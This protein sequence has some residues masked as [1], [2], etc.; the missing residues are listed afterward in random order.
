[1][2]S[3][4]MITGFLLEIIVFTAMATLDLEFV[5]DYFVPML[6]YTVILS[7]LSIIII[8]VLSR[9]CL[10]HEWFE[11]A[12]MAIGAATG[13]TSTGLALV[14]ALDPDSKSS[15]G[16]THGIYSTIMSWK[17]LFT[18]LTPLWLMTGI[19]LTVG[20]GFAIMII[21]CICAFIFAETRKA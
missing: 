7:V 21:S 15:A 6:I 2:K 11:K 12:C 17:D 18:G 9:K 10:K 8:I 14:R 3:I 20:V 13:N 1:M 5:S 16:D 19:G 4:K